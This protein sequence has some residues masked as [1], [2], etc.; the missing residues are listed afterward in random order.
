MQRKGESFA[1]DVGKL[2]LFL[3][4]YGIMNTDMKDVTLSGF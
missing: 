1:T 4:G 2:F 3:S